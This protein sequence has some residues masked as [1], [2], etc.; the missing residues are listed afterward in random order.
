METIGIMIQTVNRK[1][2]K[3]QMIGGSVKVHS[4][5]SPRPSRSHLFVNLRS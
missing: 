1:G 5:E 3:Q 4:I 2:K